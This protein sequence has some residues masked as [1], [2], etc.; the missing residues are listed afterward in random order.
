M[1]YFVGCRS[2]S[3]ESRLLVAG[4]MEADTEFIFWSRRSRPRP[5]ACPMLVLVAITFDGLRV[6]AVGSTAMIILI[7]K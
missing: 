2:V 5:V 6:H 1:G 7:I 4:P 3:E